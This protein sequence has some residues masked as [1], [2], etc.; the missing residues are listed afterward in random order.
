MELLRLVAIAWTWMIVLVLLIAGFVLV[1]WFVA[2][3][4][5]IPLLA[6]LKI[7]IP[8]TEGL[9]T[10]VSTNANRSPQRQVQSAL[11]MHASATDHVLIYRGTKYN[12][13]LESAQDS[14]EVDGV[15][16]F[17]KYRGQPWKAPSQ[18][19]LLSK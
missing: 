3:A 12:C 14:A 19:L 5:L 17:G 10:Q 11:E 4:L 6:L 15:E 13:H 2:L 18:R 9:S 8:T 16:T 7:P 1:P